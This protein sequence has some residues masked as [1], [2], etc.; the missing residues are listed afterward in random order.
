MLLPFLLASSL[1]IAAAMSDAGSS[2]PWNNPVATSSEMADD[3]YGLSIDNL[4][5]VAPVFDS[6]T[7]Y[8]MPLRKL[9][10]G[11]YPNAN[12]DKPSSLV[13]LNRTFRI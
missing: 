7:C 4:I 11:S 5:T 12:G 1:R 13:T 8:I 9:A 10:H 2:S 6:V 3:E